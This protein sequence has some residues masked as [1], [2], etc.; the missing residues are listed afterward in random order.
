MKFQNERSGKVVVVAH[1]VLNQNSR[2]FRLAHY[3][4][5]INE[6]VDV[7]RRHN[8]GF[9]QMPCP[10]LIYAGVKRFGRTREEYDTPSYRKHCKQIAVSTANQI[11]QFAQNGIKTLAI[12]GIKDS[13][14]C[15][16]DNFAK[17]AGIL[18]E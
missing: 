11:E 4:A 3:P 18:M 9:L 2:V 15:A 7:L 6:V 17:E 1:C 8:V 16:T 12:V 5:V 10:E 13:P 14:S